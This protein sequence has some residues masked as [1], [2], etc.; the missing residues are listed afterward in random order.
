MSTN[1]KTQARSRIDALVDQD[2]FV[3]IG[4]GVTSRSTDFALGK[5]AAGDGVITGYATVEG[6]LVYVYSQDSTVLGGSMGEMHAKKIVKLYD[7]AMKMGAPVIGL[8]DCAGLR[9]QETVDALEGF[10][11]L[12]TKEAAAS[13]VVP[14]ISVIFGKCGGGMAISA[15]ISDFVFMEEKDAALFVNAPNTLDGNYKEKCDT[16]SAAFQA[17]NAGIVDGFGTEEEILSKVRALVSFLPSNNEEPAVE[18]AS[19]DLNRLTAELEGVTDVRYIAQEIADDRIFFETKADFAKDMVTG[20]VRLDGV[21]TGIVANAEAVLSPKGC[22]KAASFVNFC[23]AFE[24]PLVTLVQASGYET[25]MCA[26][27]NIALDAARLTLAFAGATVPKISIVIGDAMATPYVIMNSK[28]IGADIAY[29]VES[30]KIGIMDAG[31]AAKI[32]GGDLAAVK[33]EFDEKQT[34]E[35]S[36]RRGYIDE[37]I[38]MSTIRKNILI[39]LEML[40]AKRDELPDKKHSAK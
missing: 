29:A 32:I 1:D 12:Y 2:S 28:S 37:I 39:A 10:G 4:A 24:I 23:D 35:A 9:L 40:Y 27:K 15:G 6:K 3:E 17:E 13:G 11:A 31:I 19:D 34:A 21:T 38:S 14:E 36:A 5:D 22:R 30:T 7:M 16:S 33:A 20:F 25:T 18:D 8:V 26:E